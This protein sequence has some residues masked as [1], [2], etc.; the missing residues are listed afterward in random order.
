[1]LASIL[2]LAVI[3]TPSTAVAQ[4]VIEARCAADS[5]DATAALQ[6]IEWARRCALLTNTSGPG[7]F[8]SSTKALDQVTFLGAR[9]YR[10]IGPQHAYSANIFDYDVNYSYSYCRFGTGA[11]TAVAPDSSGPTV[12]FYRWSR[13]TQRA[14][15]LYPS[16]DTTISGTGTPLFPLPTLP[17]ECK[18]YHRNPATGEFS[19][20]TGSFF[21]IAYCESI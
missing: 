18:L 17:G 10:E 5:L 1:M 19:R 4:A 3:A 9:E 15:V 13:P 12:N 16:F 6:R 11:V 14:R 20:W 2:A 21:V 7:S 8:F